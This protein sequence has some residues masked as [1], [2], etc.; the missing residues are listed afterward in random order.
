VRC[1]GAQDEGPDGKE[2]DGEALHDQIGHWMAALDRWIKQFDRGMGDHD[3]E[4]V[5]LEGLP[6]DDYGRDPSAGL[7]G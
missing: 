7:D 5:S 1:D 2:L 6:A 4:N 3:G